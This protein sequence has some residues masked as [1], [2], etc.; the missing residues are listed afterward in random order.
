[1]QGKCASYSER[2]SEH[3]H[4]AVTCILEVVGSYLDRNTGYSEV[5]RRSPDSLQANSGF[6][7][8]LVGHDRFLPDVLQF[9]IHEVP[10]HSTV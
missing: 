2:T 5:L 8:R 7:P 1:M 4:V 9:F 10:Y 6:I 3:V